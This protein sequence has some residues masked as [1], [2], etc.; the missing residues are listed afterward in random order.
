MRRY[1]FGEEWLERYPVENGLGMLV[2]S[3][4]NMSQQCV[5]TAKGAN[6]IL[7]CVRNSVASRVGH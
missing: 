3:Q 1:R 4:L 5:Q 2:G 6:S 7:A